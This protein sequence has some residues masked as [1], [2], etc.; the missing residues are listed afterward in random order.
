MDAIKK[1]VVVARRNR[2]TSSVVSDD[3]DNDFRYRRHDSEVFADG[4]GENVVGGGRSSRLSLYG[5]RCSARDLMSV[6]TSNKF[7]SDDA[8]SMAARKMLHRYENE[9]MN[10]REAIHSTLTKVEDKQAFIEALDLKYSTLLTANDGFVDDEDA[11]DEAMSEVIHQ[12]RSLFDVTLK[13]MW[14]EGEESSSS[15]MTERDAT[16]KNIEAMAEEHRRDDEYL[17][18]RRH[19]RPKTPKNLRMSPMQTSFKCTSYGNISLS[20]SCDSTCSVGSSS[21]NIFQPF[22][23]RRRWFFA[24][25][26]KRQNPERPV[27]PQSLQSS[28]FPIKEVLPKLHFD[29]GVSS[30]SNDNQGMFCG[31]NTGPRPVRSLRLDGSSAASSYMPPTSPIRK[32]SEEMDVKKID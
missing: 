23:R 9:N 7:D 31:F 20:E 12:V 14:K 21:S 25:N 30:S 18:Y 8:F 1:L 2:T 6:E 32:V 11:S 22:K 17:E 28:R 19:H 13:A 5:R 24:E 29:F 10:E 4:M 3:D 26:K 16:F 15:G 27:T